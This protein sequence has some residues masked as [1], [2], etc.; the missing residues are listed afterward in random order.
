MT[1]HSTKVSISILC[2]DFSRLAE[3][4]K[5]IEDSGADMIHVD[6]MDGHFVPPLTFGACLVK[7]IRPLTH[8]PIDAHLMVQHPE[9]L[10][11]DFIDAGADIIS[12]HA[13]CCGPLKAGCRDFGSFPKEI[14][15]F[16]I[17]AAQRMISM[18]RSAGRQPFMV[19]NPG[20]PANIIQ[21][22]LTE[23]DGVLV[24][25]VNPGFSHQK[26]IPDVVSKITWLKERFSGD[27]AIDGGINQDT[28][29][30][31]RKAGA[32]ILATASYFFSHQ[33]QKEAVASLKA[34]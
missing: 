2:A 4:V 8:L 16:D 14:E 3:E 27:I 20:T 30:H 23:I 11:P 31:A 25:S 21:P 9:S 28:A 5:R 24:M 7:A 15:S 19:L 1:D 18:I 17:E 22:V 34:L 26:F 13:E 32:N 33:D 29:V 12:I 10:I 6:A